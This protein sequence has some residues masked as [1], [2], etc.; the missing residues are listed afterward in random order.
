M[1]VP[2]KAFEIVTLGILTC[3][4]QQAACDIASAM[5]S[6]AALGNIVIC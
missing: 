4:S 6:W 1:I 5:S 2:V 3:T